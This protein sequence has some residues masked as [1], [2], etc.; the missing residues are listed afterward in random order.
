MMFKKAAASLLISLS[1]TP[2]ADAA[3][4]KIPLTKVR[5]EE[6]ASMFIQRNLE[7]DVDA[8]EEV[9]RKLSK[10]N[11][12]VQNHDNIVVKDYQNAQYFGTIKV[13]TPSQEFQVVFDTGS[14]NLWVPG[15]ACDGPCRGKSLFNAGTSNSFIGYKNKFYIRYG[16][17]P[18]SGKFAEDTVTLGEIVVPKQKL[19]VIT[20]VSGLGRLY[21]MGK[22]DGIMG[23]G[24]SSISLGKV[25]TVLDNAMQ[26]N[27]L[28]EPFFSF[29]LGD[30]ADGELTIGGVD[31]SRYVGDFHNVK[32]LSAT[33]WE[34]GLG[35]IKIGDESFVS[36]TT[37]I[38]DSG[39]SLITG[40]SHYIKTLARSVGAR[41]YAKS[42]VLDCDQADNLPDITFNIDGK[43]YTLKG[44]DYV[45]NAGDNMCLLGFSAL[46]MPSPSAPKWILGDMFMRKYYV[47]FDLKKEEVGFAKLA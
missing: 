41:K 33:Y 17:G 36:D 27:L 11:L 10:S 39:T 26:H 21:S 16:S 29:Y 8:V 4:M 2:L 5:E 6:F 24:F 7:S 3:V 30:D 45:L 14:S 20:N 42:Y 43:P 40:P 46:D 15:N 19:G 1:L 38:V 25:P 31:S 35:S 13:G 28:D 44:N 22:F 34:I 9:S 47:K 23:L 18:V 37:A 12:R 32:L